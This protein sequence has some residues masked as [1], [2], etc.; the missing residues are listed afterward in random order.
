MIRV[1]GIMLG[2]WIS[3]SVFAC[4]GSQDNPAD[5]DGGSEDGGQNLCGSRVCISSET[6]VH[7][8]ICVSSTDRPAKACAED[9]HELFEEIGPADLSCHN[10][11]ACLS[12]QDCPQDASGTSLA[13]HQGF[14]G[15]S[16]PSGTDLPDTVV[17]RGCV[18]AFGI[19]DTTHDMRIALYLPGEDPAGPSAKEVVSTKDEAGCAYWGAFE[20]HNVPTNT[21]LVL[22][23]Y[24]DNG[25]FVPTY[26][27]NLILW[28]DLATKEGDDW[29]FDTRAT[30]ADPR[31]GADL[32]LNPWRG[33][34]I[35]QTTYNVILMAVRITLPDDHGAIAGTIRDCAY[36]ELNNVRCGMAT[37]PGVM[38]YYTNAENPRP[39]LSR[40]ASHTNGIYSAISLPA[41]KHQIS[42]LAE[43]ENGQ[44]VPL[45]E[46]S[47]EVFPK[48]IT[49]AS[50]DRFPAL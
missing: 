23:T 12:D 15:I 5:D 36:R 16:P 25:N 13:C 35:S 45:G 9:E 6:C 44:Q 8:A 2:I 24:D 48:S 28:A 43:D 4:S 1:T 7:D 26:K 27:T 46:Y 30:V 38:T 49:I 47:V 3:L 22:K 40:S 37:E 33:Y 31:T 21:P 32:W 41:G 39:D 11:E 50:F 34:A 19:G 10:T 20:L 29:V 17:F 18:D 14:C 42:C